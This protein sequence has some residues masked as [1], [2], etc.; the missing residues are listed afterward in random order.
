MQ[1]VQ[2]FGVAKTNAVVVFTIVN[3]LIPLQTCCT[4]HIHRVLWCSDFAYFASY[5]VL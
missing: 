4:Y 5:S 3:I 1:P 2:S